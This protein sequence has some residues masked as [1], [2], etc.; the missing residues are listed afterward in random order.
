MCEPWKNRLQ[1]RQS[2]LLGQY[3][4]NVPQQLGQSRR[5]LCLNEVCASTRLCGELKKH[6]EEK[7]TKRR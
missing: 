4:Q 6:P 2:T 3:A 1:Q 5:P 7:A